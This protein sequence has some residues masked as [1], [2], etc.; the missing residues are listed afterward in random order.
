MDA[1]RQAAEARVHALEEELARL[2]AEFAEP[3]D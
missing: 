3:K 2:R 1:A